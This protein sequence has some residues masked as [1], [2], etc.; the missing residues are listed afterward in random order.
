M[1][2][3][4]VSWSLHNRRLVV[5]LTVVLSALA[6][7]GATRMRFD[8]LPDVTSNQVLVL[9]RAPGLTPEEVERLVTRPIESALGGVPGIILQRSL[10]RYGIS[11]V[12]TVFED[13][14]DPFRAR[15]VVQ[16][17]LN[18]VAGELP[19]GIDPPELGPLTGG[20]GEIF[21][22]VLSSPRRTPAEL[23]E[24]V[25]LRVAPLLRA[26]PGVV[27]VNQWGGDQRTFD[28][29]AR[30]A[31]MARLH[32][33][34]PM[35]AEALKAAVGSAPG[36][37]VAAGSG[38]ALLRGVAWPRTPGELATAIVR[39][40][41]TTVVR[42]SDVAD[43]VQAAVA[44]IGTATANGRGETVYVMVQMLR[45]ANALE[46]MRA[47]H[48]R[49]PAVQ[50]ALPA[51][52]QI[53]LVYDRSDLVHRTLRTV[54]ANLAEGGALVVAVL[55]VLL[56]SLRAGVMVAL[57]IPLS[58]LGAAL[59]MVGLS[60]A[61]NLMSL[62]AIDFGL[63]VD[64]GVVMVEALFHHL[65]ESV[66]PYGQPAE[67]EE[68]RQ[69]RI[70]E[71]CVSVARPIFFG[72]IVILLVYVP[73]LS[74]QAVDG[75]M[76][77]PMAVT[78]ILAL[79]ASL[80]LALTFVPAAASLFLRDRDIPKKEPLLVRAAQAI[81][82]PILAVSMR[83]AVPVLVAAVAM[84]GG[85]LWLFMGSG[86]SFVPQLDEGDL[87]VQMTRAPDI[88]IETAADAASRMEHLLISRVPE[89]QQVVSR[90]GSPAVATDI[91]GLDQ[92]DVFV[93]LKPRAQWRP[94]LT[95]D[96]LIDEMQAL[97]SKYDPGGAASFTQPIQMRFNELLG[98]SVT[99]VAVSVYGQDL[100]ELRRIAEQV[101]A[102][103]KKAKGA[104]DVRVLAPPPVSLVEV[105]PIALQAAQFG[106]TSRDVLDTVQA[107][108]TGL[109]VGHTY[110]G[111]VRIPVRVRIAGTPTAFTLA[112]L[113][114]STVQGTLVP[115][116]RIADV[117]T[118]QTSGLVSREMAQRR[119][120]VGFN[121]R[122][123]DLG[124]VAVAAQNAVRA[125]VRMPE[126]YRVEWGGQWQTFA[127]AR[128]RM[129]VVMPVV[130]ALI[131]GVLIWTFGKLRPA[132]LILLN[133]PFACVG[134]VALLVM[135]D[136]PV[137]MSAAVG[138]IALSG[139]AV[140]NGVVLMAQMLRLQRGGTEAAEAMASA[141]MSRMRPVL[142]T[143]L[144]AMLGFVPMMLATGAGAEV[145]RP[146]ATVVV[147]GL[148]TSTALTLIVLPALVA[149]LARHGWAG[150]PPQGVRS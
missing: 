117:R 21:H 66:P 145:Q 28:A 69:K 22:F 23:M 80:L 64:G 88:S 59:G 1:I 37:S 54:G 35:L 87:I 78:V 43:V 81:Y 110:D 115:L 140:M 74:L 34:L 111:P 67:S 2:E 91:M 36:A 8:A 44:R 148:V 94:G 14:V 123:G 128:K 39:M 132:M 42:V 26:V 71:V 83:R 63:L 38:Q 138:F 103:C 73:I 141:A 29:V 149:W 89:V 58:M 20:L 84:L 10:S 98:G 100:G 52:V 134:G 46:V 55:L 144:V 104:E 60:A 49:M 135:R 47:I 62:G 70:E 114:L 124:E 40:D 68:T 112:D 101:A 137:S 75:K 82:R 133:V 108:R 150:G 97:L 147:G 4:L 142:M 16:E 51:D 119:I 102:A 107:V 92:S 45:E 27:E 129:S 15:Q 120:V 105:Q 95:K 85:G 19:G 116:S 99:D 41:G 33:T 30:P 131:I 121:V 146:L 13:D 122:G 79:A 6:G 3:W 126:G 136:M 72:K 96:A 7:L 18:I 5:V 12:T 24:M 57:V 106:M 61:G 118:T 86:S 76:F 25:Q 127:E 56:G 32:V 125:Q 93:T 11:S 113:P 9:T 90:I 139:I 50:E 109:T 130:L 53:R 17:R 77:R 65:A 48:E 31:D 143:A